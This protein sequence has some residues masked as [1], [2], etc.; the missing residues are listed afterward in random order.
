MDEAEG[1]A[2]PV[3]T[4]RGFGWQA[5]FFTLNLA[6]V[7]AIAKFVTP[8]FAGWT[9]GTLLPLLQRPTSSSSFEFFY[10]HL[11]AFSVIPASLSGLVNAK[12][13]QKVA[14]FVW[15]VPAVVLAYKLVTFHP[16]SV[17]QSRFAAAFHQYFGGGF[18]IPEFRD[19]REF[20]SI[21]RSTPDMLRGLAQAEYTAPF[22][23]GVAYS[24]AAWIGRR[25]ELSEKSPKR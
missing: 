18:S 4:R 9:R 21:V 6:A 25:A 22:Y 17:L 11:L 16:A 24:I 14:E 15:L 2:P 23:A 5:L 7:Y 8:Y 20:W 1:Q 19:W 12:F 3:A 13:R 10:S